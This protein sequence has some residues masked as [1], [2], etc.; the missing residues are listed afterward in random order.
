M[1]ED[2]SDK[3]LD[4]LSPMAFEVTQNSATEPP[5]TGEYHEFDKSGNYYCI[6]CDNLLFQSDQKFY[7]SCGWPA[8]SAALANSTIEKN[9]ISHNMNRNEIL[10]KKCEAHLGHKFDDGPT[11]T[12]YCINSVSLKF[13]E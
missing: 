12:R 1:N 8:F 11:G 7:S 9:D 3:K 10:C 4:Q 5:F 6:C 13:E 2:L